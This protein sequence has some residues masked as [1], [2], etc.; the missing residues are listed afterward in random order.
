LTHAT[1]PTA[2]VLPLKGVQEWDR[3]GEVLHAPQAHRAFVDEVRAHVQPPVQVVELDAHI[4]D[5]AFA[6]GVLEIFDDWVARGV[7]SAGQAVV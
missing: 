2:L 1:G 3:P 5:G 6:T 7:I 4:N